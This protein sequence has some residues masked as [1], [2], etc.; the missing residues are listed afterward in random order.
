[1]MLFAIVLIENIFQLATK[2]RYTEKK[3]ETILRQRGFK[4]T[5]QR[6]TILNAIT[7]SHEHLT[8]AAHGLRD[9]VRAAGFRAHWSFPLSR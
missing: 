6:R 1:M 7:L 4:I 2:M 5:P 8:P 3:I 9:L